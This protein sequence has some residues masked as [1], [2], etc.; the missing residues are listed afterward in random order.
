MPRVPIPVVGPAYKS[1]ELPLSA[2]VTKNLWPEINQEAR[3]VVSLHHT[4]GCKNFSAPGGTDRGMHIFNERMFCVSGTTL[5][6]ID[7]DGV[8]TD[9]GSIPGEERVQFADD[10]S[11]LVMVTAGSVYIYTD[12]TNVDAGGVVTV[13]DSDLIAP[14][15]VAYLNQQFLFDQNDGTPGRFATSEIATDFN[16]NALDVAT[17]E[18]HPDDIVRLI[19]FRQNVFMFG[20]RSVEPWYNTGQG[21]PPFARVNNSIRPYGIAGINAAHTTSEWLYFLDHDRIPRRTQ[22]LDHQNIGNPALGVQWSRYG[23]LNDCIVFSY[24]QDGQTFVV[25]TFPT[26]DRTWVFHEPSMSWFQWSYGVNDERSLANSCVNIFGQWFAAGHSDGNIYQLDPCTY[27]DN[28]NVIQRRRA[29]AAIHGGLYNMPG[30]TLFF[31]RVE[32]VIATGD[33]STQA[34]GTVPEYAADQY[35]P[36][37]WEDLVWM[38]DFNWLQSPESNQRQTPIYEQRQIG[39]YPGTFLLDNHGYD[40]TLKGPNELVSTE[41]D[42]FGETGPDTGDGRVY[43]YEL[44][45]PYDANANYYLGELENGAWSGNETW[46]FGF[47]LNWNSSDSLAGANKWLFCSGDFVS[48]PTYGTGVYKDTSD[49]IVFQLVDTLG[50]KQTCT[51]TSA[52]AFDDDILLAFQFDPT[53]GEMS[54]WYSVTGSDQVTKIGTHTVTQTIADSAAASQFQPIIGAYNSGTYGTG[55]AETKIDQFWAFGSLLSEDDLKYLSGAW[56]MSATYALRNG[57][58]WYPGGLP[59]VLHMDLSWWAA[60]YKNSGFSTPQLGHTGAGGTGWTETA[61]DE[62]KTIYCKSG[63]VLQIE[64]NDGLPPNPGDWPLLRNDATSGLNYLELRESRVQ[65][66]SPTWRSFTRKAQVEGTQNVD[67]SNRTYVVVAKSRVGGSGGCVYTTY[68]DGG[69]SFA[70][71]KNELW[72]SDTE[73]RFREVD[74]STKAVLTNVT[75]SD[76]L[77]ST[78]KVFVVTVDN[79]DVNIYTN[80]TTSQGSGTLTTVAGSGNDTLTP[81]FFAD[82]WDYNLNKASTNEYNEDLG[83]IA[84]YDR[85]LTTAELDILFTDLKAK[86]AIT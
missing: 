18:S 17:A 9:K 8:A 44:T 66:I 25:Y 29:T 1:R 15:S 12:P 47:K 63:S 49:Q 32:F 72:L 48:S 74:S 56:D 83:E 70:V 65:K 14:T 69:F 28:G 71:K 4:P 59:P 75:T 54:I 73:F 30:K 67:Y 62:I 64:A 61:G 38:F 33:C 36:P 46:T 84:I 57:Y 58:E 22:G 26:E 35:P 45:R 39:T 20:S 11:K 34:L 13:T 43:C 80:N 16:V 40:N 21:R 41:D 3:N 77:E 50:A 82:T 7:S 53:S 5:F 60:P 85:A 81:L 52:I 31:D 51:S 76:A 6:E 78:F 27:T 86:W 42:Y 24:R 23:T 2:Q 68:N 79:G 19:T 55:H 10:G 37:A